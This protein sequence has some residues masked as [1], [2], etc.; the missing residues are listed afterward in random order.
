AEI[1]AR[2]YN[3]DPEF[4]AFNRSLEAYRESFR[5]KDGVLVL[6]KNSEFFRYFGEDARR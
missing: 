1:Y 3:T 4:Y 2:A 5:G 6:D